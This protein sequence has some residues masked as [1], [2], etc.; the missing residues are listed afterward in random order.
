[1]HADASIKVGSLGRPCLIIHEQPVEKFRFRYKSEMHG[2]HGSLSGCSS[3]KKKTFPSVRLHGYADKAII[4]C[5]LHQTDKYQQ[6]LHSHLLVVR[7]DDSDCRDPHEVHVNADEGYRA[8]F[9]GMGII[10]TAR[11]YI[12]DELFEKLLDRYKLLNGKREATE[13]ERERLRLR[14]D[15]ESKEMN[16][17]QVCLCFEAFRV[18]GDNY[19]RLCEPVYSY[20]INNMSE[21]SFSIVLHSPGCIFIR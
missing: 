2:T 1:M 10:H 11:K 19:E 9:P 5:T 7:R 21:C 15:K 6:R 8:E 20:P 12:V 3:G 16:L 17:N 4:Q 14:A 13:L 18:V